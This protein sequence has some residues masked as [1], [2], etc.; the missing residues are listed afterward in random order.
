MKDE[1]KIK[2]ET[3]KYNVFWEFNKTFDGLREYLKKI[4][5]DNPEFFDFRLE[6]DNWE[7]ASIEVIAKRYET[8]EEV[9]RREERNKKSK[10]ASK[11][12]RKK[13]R[14]KKEIADKILLKKLKD[15]YER[16]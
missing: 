7:D 1:K 4:E 3:V 8:D 14:D 2:H 12:A 10:T 11:I 16:H 9:T 13:R 15:K 6:V 5:V